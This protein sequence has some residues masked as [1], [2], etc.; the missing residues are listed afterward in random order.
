MGTKIYE[1]EIFSDFEITINE[2]DGSQGDL[3]AIP[4]NVLSV[5][6]GPSFVP[7]GYSRNGRFYPKDLW[8][9]SLKNNEFK[10]KMERRLVFGCI[11]HPTGDYTLD[12]LL[13]SGK[14]S[15][16]V[17]DMKIDGKQGICEFHILDT[18][19][20]RILDAVLKAGSKPYVSTRAFG[21]FTNETKKKDGKEYKILDKNNFFIESVDFVIDPGFLEASPKLLESLEENFKELSEDPK[22]IK[23]EDGIC[24]LAEKLSTVNESKNDNELLDTMSLEEL[25]E[26]VISISKENKKLLESDESEQNV[27][28]EKEAEAA[29]A[30]E[31]EVKTKKINIYLSYI[32]LL[33]KLLKYDV[34]YEKTYNAL[35]EFLDKDD[36][37]SEDEMKKISELLSSIKD[38]EETDESIIHIINKL[39]KINIDV[40][41]DT[42]D[43]DNFKTESLI[44]YF[45]GKI[46]AM[47]SF[48]NSSEENLMISNTLVKSINTL[49]LQM[50]EKESSFKEFTKTKEMYISEIKKE[51]ETYKTKISNLESNLSSQQDLLNEKNEIIYSLE[52][53]KNNDRSLEK[54]AE[55]KKELI[56]KIDSLTN[57]LSES[58]EI[59]EST[60]NKFNENSA[61]ETQK[62]SK[63]SAEIKESKDTV[64]KTTS[65]YRGMLIENLGLLFPRIERSIIESNAQELSFDKNKIKE[66]LNYLEKRLPKQHI[67][68]GVTGIVEKKIENT[69]SVKRSKFLENL[70]H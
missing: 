47:E 37:L 16:I 2:A 26:M 8:E 11:G 50:E 31:E 7:D 49:T 6:K 18:P 59:I 64:D 39:E 45:E 17:T 3:G 44:N 41:D 46:K 24:I 10:S 9:T 25:K 53:N 51:A 43:D 34:K 20:G 33:I 1:N 70:T 40:S 12:E 61:L 63:L 56:E 67:Y 66:K 55:E 4:N 28:S 60:K 54:L 68:D 65:L 57:E 38:A 36:S 69:E 30:A 35:I 13:E 22:H 48:K 14:V 29:K 21:G 42:S 27:D 58:K 23:C 19:S 32:E 52:N 15:H 5:V 62:I